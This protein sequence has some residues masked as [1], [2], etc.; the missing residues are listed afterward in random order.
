MS[1]QY[2]HYLQMPDVASLVLE[3]VP[4]ESH[5][6][7][8][9]PW[10]DLRR[11]NKTFFEQ[12]TILK[13]KYDIKKLNRLQ[14]LR[15]ANQKYGVTV[16]E[17]ENSPHHLRSMSEEDEMTLNLQIE[18]ASGWII[19]TCF[20]L[21]HKHEALKNRKEYSS[22]AVHIFDLYQLFNDITKRRTISLLARAAIKI[23][24]SSFYKEEIVDRI[25]IG[26]F[27]V[28]EILEMERE[29]LNCLSEKFD[30]YV[31]FIEL[32]FPGSHVLTF[33]ERYIFPD[34]RKTFEKKMYSRIAN[35]P[36]YVS[37]LEIFV[38]FAGLDMGWRKRDSPNYY[39]ECCLISKGS[40]MGPEA[41]A[42][43]IVMY[44]LRMQGRQDWNDDLEYYT[45]YRREVIAQF[46]NMVAESVQ[47][48][49]EYGNEHLDS[50]YK[51]ISELEQSSNVIGLYPSCLRHHSPIGIRHSVPWSNSIYDTSICSPS[52]PQSRP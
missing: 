47:Y 1:G 45:G 9:T 34:W 21:F 52:S 38:D 29:V 27:S 36:C 5:F 33:S 43:G 37:F 50:K 32:M 10:S 4:F 12:T 11:V 25:T 18:E 3:K 16:D 28:S 31:P 19:S 14:K 39:L 51:I 6:S 48:V 7:Q 26:L 20:E 8:E 46:A 35:L 24:A 49:E 22:F 42:C 15:Q 41:V 17:I 40:T 23:V 30:I 13:G 44:A 2:S